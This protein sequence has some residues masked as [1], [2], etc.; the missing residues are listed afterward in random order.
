VQGYEPSKRTG[1]HV[2]EEW[3]GSLAAA[4]AL[5]RERAPLLLDVESA[6]ERVDRSGARPTEA[7]RL[8]QALEGALPGPG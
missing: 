3:P 7:R 8:A 2:W 6:D 4:S 1:G 5:G